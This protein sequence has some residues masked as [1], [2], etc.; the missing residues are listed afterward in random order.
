[1]KNPKV[2]EIGKAFGGIA[3]KEI[4]GIMAQ[5]GVTLKSHA[6]VM[7]N[8][9]LDILFTHYTNLN[10]VDSLEQIF[11]SVGGKDEEVKE[12]KT[13]ETAKQKESKAKK[14]EAA[15]ENA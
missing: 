6:A 5:Y 9:D 13:K 15:E 10:K 12:E 14:A 8:K 4:I 3:S 1:M 11:A 2:S 7:S